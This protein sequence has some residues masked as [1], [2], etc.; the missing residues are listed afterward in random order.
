MRIPITQKKGTETVPLGHHFGKRLPFPLI[1][2][3]RKEMVP[4][5]KRE[6]FSKT[7]PQGS[8]FS[9]KGW[10]QCPFIK[11]GTVLAPLGSRFSTKK[12]LEMAPLGPLWLCF[13][14]ENA[15]ENSALLESGTKTGPLKDLFYGRS[16]AASREP[17]WCHLFF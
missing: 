8:R 11:S 13:C 16:N 9:K 10:K 2:I 17:F 3:F 4:L 12:R 5:E 15:W 7:A 1:I 6:P 14:I